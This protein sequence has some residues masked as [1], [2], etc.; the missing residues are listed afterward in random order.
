MSMYGKKTQQY[1]KVINLQLMKI[2][3]KKKTI[4]MIDEY[5]PWERIPLT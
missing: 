5:I 1:C 4:I 3:E 2:N